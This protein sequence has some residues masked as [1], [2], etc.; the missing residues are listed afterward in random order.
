VDIDVTVG[1]NLEEISLEVRES[2]FFY[3]F[4]HLHHHQ[5]LFFNICVYLISF[6]FKC[7]VTLIVCIQ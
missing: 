5:L 2:C 4:P 3:P 1:D 6:F 7:I